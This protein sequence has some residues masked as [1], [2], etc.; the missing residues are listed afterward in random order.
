MSSG[1]LSGDQIFFG[2]E[3]RLEFD[4]RAWVPK[5]RAGEWLV[6]H[7]LFVIVA[8]KGA[9]FLSIQLLAVSWEK[10]CRKSVKLR[11]C[12]IRVKERAQAIPKN[13]FLGP[14][15]SGHQPENYR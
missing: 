2:K 7:F 10:L 6:Q 13:E 14:A 4:L 3:E 9:F 11:I 12:Y 5:G 1:S 15:N 8:S